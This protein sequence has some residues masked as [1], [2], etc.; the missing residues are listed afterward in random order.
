MITHK[1]MPTN[2]LQDLEG[3]VLSLS[4]THIVPVLVL[5]GR[6]RALRPR[7]DRLRLEL[8]VAACDR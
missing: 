5:Q 3:Q 7:A 1:H 2:L 8:E 4:K 6:L